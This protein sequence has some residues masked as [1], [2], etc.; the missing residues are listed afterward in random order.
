MYRVWMA[1]GKAQVVDFYVPGNRWEMIH[2]LK[3]KG[4]K[5]LTKMKY[6][7]L[8]AIYCRKRAEEMK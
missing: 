6:K 8:Q 3:G 1:K 5:G 2:Y 4:M 7:V